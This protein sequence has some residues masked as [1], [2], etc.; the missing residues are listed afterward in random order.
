M[1][2]DQ[3]VTPF[4]WFERNAEEAANHYVSTFARSK[5]LSASPSSVELVLDGQKLILFNGGSAFKFTPAISLFVSCSTQEEIDSYWS[6]LLEGGRPSRCGWLTDRYG[7]SWQIVPDVLGELLQDED[8]EREI[9][10]A[11]V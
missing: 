9:G 2:A 1:Q 6:K 3:K 8:R 10:R 11:H 4:L 5:I 7:V